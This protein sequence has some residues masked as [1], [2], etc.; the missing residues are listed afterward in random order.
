MGAREGTIVG[1]SLLAM[2][3]L[4]S[5]VPYALE[6]VQPGLAISRAS[7]QTLP[8]FLDDNRLPA[9][10][11]AWPNGRP[12]E[13][14]QPGSTLQSALPVLAP[15][16]DSATSVRQRAEELSRRFGAGTGVIHDAAPETVPS[17]TVDNEVMPPRKSA[18]NATE[19]AA[20]PQSPTDVATTD[21]DFAHQKLR[22]AAPPPPPEKVPPLPRRAPETRTAIVAPKARAVSTEPA[23]AEVTRPARSAR[24]YSAAAATHFNPAAPPPDPKAALRGTI[25]TNELSSFGWNSQP[26]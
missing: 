5:A 22:L 10:Q 15:S 12:A 1:S 25:M 4:A 21:G 16:A 13:P 24:A 14:S 23:R 3:V 7:A 19:T 2:C 17:R 8:K 9:F 26:K 11:E 6:P 18:M 20:I